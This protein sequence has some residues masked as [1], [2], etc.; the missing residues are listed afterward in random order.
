MACL[1]KLRCNIL[2]LA[3]AV[4][5]VGHQWVVFARPHRACLANAL[6]LKLKEYGCDAEV[7]PLQD[8][9]F[10]ISVLIPHREEKPLSPAQGC[11]CIFN[12]AGEF[13]PCNFH[14]GVNA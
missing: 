6:P 13:E 1:S 5:T 4:S 8:G 14:L 11:G 7:F 9:R 3:D 2:A 10:Q 12:N